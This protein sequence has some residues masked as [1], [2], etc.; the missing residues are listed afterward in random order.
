MMT[1]MNKRQFHTFLR[2]NICIRSVQ[3]LTPLEQH[4]LFGFTGDYLCTNNWKATFQGKHILDNWT[5]ISAINAERVCNLNN[6]VL[7][8]LWKVSLSTL[9]FNIEGKDSQWCHFRPF[10]LGFARDDFI[11]ANVSF[12]LLRRQKET[13]L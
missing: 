11:V 6:R 10:A 13:S 3:K 5:C 12:N 2:E 9:T 7:L 4:V 1:Q 8:C